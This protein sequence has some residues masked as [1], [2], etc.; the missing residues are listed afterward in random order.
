M[1]QPDL[2]AIAGTMPHADL[3]LVEEGSA[4]L[5]RLP[6]RWRP[7]AAAA[8]PETRLAMALDLW[9]PALLDAL[10]R[11]AAGLRERFVDARPCLA[12]G[13]PALLYLAL[14]PDGHL[15]SWTGLDPA[16]FVEPQFWGHFPEPLRTFLR[17]V[18]AGFTS[19][20]YTA[21]G[22]VHPRH[23]QTVAE[24]A[25]EPD[26]L[27]DWDEE[28]EIASTRLLLVASNGGMVNYCVSPDL[29]PGELAIVFEG[30]ID[31]TPYGEALDRL[32]VRRLE[33]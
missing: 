26:G 12:D 7:I 25:G 30:D 4:D 9:N 33:R 10:P 31:P 14:H 20:G 21:F 22:P 13:E 16:G 1:S 11:F 15:L 24:Q 3:T 29:E 17:E 28:Q 23:M 27:A 8:H 2:T 6:G 5:G 32:L 18:H 19:G